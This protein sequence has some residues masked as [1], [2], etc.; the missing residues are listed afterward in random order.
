MENLM[1]L[2]D[3]LWVLI[4][5]CCMVL[6]C[7]IFWIVKIFVL[8]NVKKVVFLFGMNCRGRMFILIRLEWWMCLQFL[9]MI[10]V[11]FRSLG[12]LVV[13]FWFELVLYFLLVRMISGVVFWVQCFVMLKIGWILLLGR[14]IVRLFLRLESIWLWMWLLVKVLC[15]I[16]LWLLC[17]VLQE[18]NWFIGILWVLR[19]SL[20]GEFCWMLLVGEM[21]LV[22]ML[23][24]SIVSICV[25]LIFGKVVGG[26][27][28][29]LLKQFGCLMQVEVGDQLQ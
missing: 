21:W 17:W 18:L 28:V 10:V 14:W 29:M 3:G 16:I 2:L 24:F 22:V 19:Y 8:V 27:G 1:I 26:L 12:F 20:V 9:V 15:I 25:F 13:Q 23:L 5:S 4:V 6:V 11:M 7:L